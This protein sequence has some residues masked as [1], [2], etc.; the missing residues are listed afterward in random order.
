MS[1]PLAVLV[2]ATVVF[3]I[4]WAWQAMQ[5]SDD[6]AAQEAVET[7]KQQM[8]ELHEALGR[9]WDAIIHPK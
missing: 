7:F 6:P 8:D 1:I 4:R 5:R 2:A 3:L 9:L